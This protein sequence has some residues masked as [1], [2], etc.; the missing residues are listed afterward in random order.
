MSRGAARS[1]FGVLLLITACYEQPELS[2]SWQLDRL[3]IL[4]VAA[5]PAEPT[6][7]ETVQFEALVWSPDDA[8]VMTVWFACLPESAD[9]FGCEVDPALLEAFE[10][11]DP[12]S[13]DP[14]QMAE[15]YETA[16]DAG[17]IGV[18]PYLPP[19][20]E[21]PGD[22]LDDLDDLEAQEGKSALVTIQAIPAGAEDADDI[23]IAYKR[24]PISLA[25]TANNNPE[26]SGLQVAGA[27]VAAGETISLEPGETVSISATLTEDSVEDYVYTSSTGEQD[28][29]TEEPYFTWYASAGEFEDTTTLWPLTTVRYTAPDSG[30]ADVIVT[31]RDR[32][33]GMAWAVLSVTTP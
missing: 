25:E 21:V 26:I 12:E 2:E 8:D 1:R 15:L 9:E 24:V 30:E 19:E 13:V 32:R 31:L 5:E 11:V 4:A 33:G 6:P 17:L 23:E 16:K 3:R 7:G 20:W 28:T 22:A 14:E 29:R 10:D 27:D 18:E